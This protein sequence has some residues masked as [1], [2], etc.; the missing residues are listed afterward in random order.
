MVE[1][2]PASGN[3]LQAL[4]GRCHCGNVQ[5]TL[6]TR[7]RLADIVVRICRCEFCLRHRPRHWSD[8]EGT[9]AIRIEQADE[10]V[11]YRFGHGTADFVICRRC[12]VYCFAIA[13]L[14]GGWHAVTNLNLALG[15]DAQPRETF[16]EALDEDVAQ[17]TRR[18]GAKWTPVTTPWPPA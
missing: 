9:V 7:E 2:Q 10:L 13:G 15:R 6:R 16:L 8:P 4:D 5:Y 12:G 17:R 11:L 1:E 14:D 18:R 3:G